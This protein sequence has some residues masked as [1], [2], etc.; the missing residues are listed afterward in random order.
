[1]AKKKSRKLVRVLA[2]G[3]LGE[4]MKV[5]DCV[6]IRGYGGQLGWIVEFRG[7]LG[8]DGA[9]IYRV[10]VPKKPKRSYIEVR[11]DQLELIEAPT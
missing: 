11:E 7:P 5:G 2:R 3:D 8:P 9:R 10:M 4:L 6:R 1:M